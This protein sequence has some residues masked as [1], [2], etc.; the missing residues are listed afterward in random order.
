ML[1]LTKALLLA[2]TAFAQQIPVPPTVPALSLGE[3]ANIV[4]ELNFIRHDYNLR[5]LELN[6]QLTCMASIQAAWLDN[7]RADCRH[8]DLSPRAEICGAVA[9][10][11]E[12]QGCGYGNV[13]ELMLGF[14]NSPSHRKM[15][16][17]PRLKRASASKIDDQWVITLGY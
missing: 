11:G 4:S 2:H 1:M 15:I 9:V 6:D 8:T 14:L 17:D 10:A 7:M 3:S 13:R 16:L 5:E 12:V